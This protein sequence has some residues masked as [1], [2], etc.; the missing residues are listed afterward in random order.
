MHVINGCLFTDTIDVTMVKRKKKS[1]SL[2]RNT[3]GSMHNYVY[4]CLCGG[5][6]QP[7][8]T[9]FVNFYLEFQLNPNKE[10]SE[11]NLL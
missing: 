9:H 8:I 1:C 4:Y 7:I 6:H 10:N 3:V 5:V 11:L 2:C